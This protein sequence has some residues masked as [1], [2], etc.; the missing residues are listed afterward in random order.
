MLPAAQGAVPGA[1]GAP[2]VL[3]APSC[4]PGTCGS[5]PPTG[6]QQD[7]PVLHSPRAVPTAEGLQRWDKAGQA[8]VQGWFRGKALNI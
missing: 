6:V 5:P 7:P 1:F 3:S 8:L 4:S 2:A